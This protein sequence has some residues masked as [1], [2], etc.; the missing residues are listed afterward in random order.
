MK[1]ILA[2]TKEAINGHEQA[3]LEFN[4]L[5]EENDIEKIKYYCYFYYPTYN[6]DNFNDI[7]IHF[8]SFPN[9]YFYEDFVDSLPD[10]YVCF[11]AKDE[12]LNYIYI[13]LLEKDFSILR[14][15]NKFY[16][17]D[18]YY[19]SEQ[20]TDIP[21]DH[22]NKLNDWLLTNISSKDK[23]VK[24][25]IYFGLYNDPLFNLYCLIGR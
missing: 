24:N 1:N 23:L 3:I 8:I 10:P 9:L 19:F 17:N 7:V 20:D 11:E 25:K 13:D 14:I 18:Y 2:L 21:F 6:Y 12:I 16:S 22:L 5:L 15:N 4:D